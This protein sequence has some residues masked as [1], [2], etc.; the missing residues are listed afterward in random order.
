MN[1]RVTGARTPAL[2]VARPEKGTAPF[3]DK[4]LMEGDT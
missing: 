2:I 3:H 4:I 1:R